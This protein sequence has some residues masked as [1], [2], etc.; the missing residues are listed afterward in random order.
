LSRSSVQPDPDAN[1]DEGAK[2]TMNPGAELNPFFFGFG[3]AKRGIEHC[4]QQKP[5]TDPVPHLAFPLNEKGPANLRTWAR[6][7]K[8]HVHTIHAGVGSATTTSGYTRIYGVISHGRTFGGLA[9][10]NPFLES[11]P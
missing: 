10:I 5:M 11:A 9:I 6:R 7:L 1:R 2:A 4:Q 3:V 8:R